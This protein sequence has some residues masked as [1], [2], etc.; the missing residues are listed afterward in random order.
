M[1]SFDGEI[2]RGRQTSSDSSSSRESSQ[3]RTT[4]KRSFTP[5]GSDDEYVPAQSEHSSSSPAD[6]SGGS[7]PLIRQAVAFRTKTPENV[8]TY[9]AQPPPAPKAFLPGQQVPVPA[10]PAPVPEPEPKKSRKQPSKRP[11]KADAYP[12]QTSRFRITTYDPT[13][14]TEPPIN[15]GS[16]PYS[17]MY[18]GV[19]GPQVRNRQ[20]PPSNA[21][22]ASTS[23]GHPGSVT[24]SSIAATSVP[25]PVAPPNHYFAPSPSGPPPPISQPQLHHRQ[26]LAVPPG[27]PV[28]Q[29][30]AQ[31]GQPVYNSNQ[32][33]PQAPYPPPPPARSASQEVGSYYRRDYD[34]KLWIPDPM[35]SPPRKDGRLQPQQQHKKRPDSAE[36]ERKAKYPVRMVTLLIRDVRSGTTDRQLVEVKVGL[37]PNQPP[38]VGF[39][40]DAKEIGEQLQQGPSRIDGPARAFTMRGKYRQFIL[41][42][43]A[44]NQDETHGGNV[45]INPERTL[46]MTVELLQPP[47]RPPPPPVIPS[48]YEDNDIHEHPMNPSHLRKHPKESAR[49]MRDPWE[50]ESDYRDR[51]GREDFREVP[52]ARDRRSRERT[53]PLQRQSSYRERRSRERES[54]HERQEY[55]DYPPLRERRSR[56]RSLRETHDLYER[57][58][59]WAVNSHGRRSPDRRDPYERKSSRERREY[60]DRR[61]MR[62]RMNSPSFDDYDGQDS[63][64]GPSH[65]VAAKL[66]RRDY[67]YENS[68][69][70]SPRHRRSP[71]PTYPL[72]EVGPPR[73]RKAQARE[74]MAYQQSSR[75]S[76]RKSPAGLGSL[77]ASSDSAARHSVTSPRPDVRGNKIHTGDLNHA[78]FMIAL[79]ELVNKEDKKGF[80]DFFRAKGGNRVCDIWSQYRYF[81]KLVATFVGR[82]IDRFELPI[83]ELHL[84]QTLKVEDGPTF[85]DEYKETMRLMPLYYAEDPRQVLRYLDPR[86]SELLEDTNPRPPTY[87]PAKELLKLLRDLDDAWENGSRKEKSFYNPAPPLAPPAAQS[88]TSKSDSMSVDEGEQS[89]TRQT[90]GMFVQ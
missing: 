37:R 67:D 6:E 20:Q 26:S 65:P 15:Q 25:Q 58:D 90:K 84:L 62:K 27:P 53:E 35:G 71:S 52:H 68:P 32:Y 79:E 10:P 77:S 89:A 48:D 41:R 23:N 29:A 72:Q 60:A 69:H 21:P 39:W 83:S 81:K 61:E 66:A 16:G 88:S 5:A 87:Q 3:E 51:R 7:Q 18:R 36:E 50:Y 82:R 75:S 78:D 38:A 86:V 24:A 17:S 13:P 28:G 30:P 73:V 49:E 22:V 14:S 44:N 63:T 8:A 11:R 4:S 47:G 55:R 31:Q 34:R 42:V 33:T 43:S 70:Q 40:A 56:E 12:G 57:Q 46:D 74:A 19:L 80:Q 2:G 45:Y 54:F 85:L 64:A 9:E 1:K 76:G 59:P